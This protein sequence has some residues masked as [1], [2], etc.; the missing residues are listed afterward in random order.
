MRKY[1][2][3]MLL[4][5]GNVSAANEMAYLPNKAGGSIFFTFS[6]CVYK[7][8]NQPI[9][10]YFYVY[11]TDQSGSRI[12]D[13]CYQYKYPFYIVEWNTGSRSSFNVNNVYVLKGN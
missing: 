11:S 1:L 3:A 8:N 9:A 6:G 12:A 13:G 4:A 2:L 5:T 10:D 7:S